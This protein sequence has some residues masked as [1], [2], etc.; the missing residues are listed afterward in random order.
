MKK[1]FLLLIL[2]SIVSA[3]LS[4]KAFSSTANFSS[5]TVSSNKGQLIFFDRSKGSVY[6]YG[7]ANGRFLYS[8]EI[9]ELGQDLN[10]NKA[11]SV[12]QRNLNKYNNET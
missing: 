12:W 2:V 7:Q 4:V 11:E 1:M 8:W 9:T 3:A 6:V 5:V 10:E